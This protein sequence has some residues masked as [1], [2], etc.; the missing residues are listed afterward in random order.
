[1]ENPHIPQ[2]PTLGIAQ[3]QAFHGRDSCSNPRPSLLKIWKDYSGHRYI[4]PRKHSPNVPARRCAELAH[5]FPAELRW[6]FVSDIVRCRRC[7]DTPH[8]H[9]PAR[10]SQSQPLL[11]LERTHRRKTLEV[12]VKP[13]RAH[14]HPISQV[15]DAQMLTKMVL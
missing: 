13:G 11:E 4:R 15:V 14:A 7:I 5:V 1:M 10:F 12:M 9:Q 3:H 8:K 6:T 2:R